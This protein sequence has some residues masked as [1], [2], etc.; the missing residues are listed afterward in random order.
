MLFEPFVGEFFSENG[1]NMNLRFGDIIIHAKI[2][3]AKPILRLSQ[4]TQPLDAG[5][6]FPCAAR[7]E[8][9]S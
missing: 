6:C 3:H 1:E 4:T 8:G 9:E 7:G 2:I 5:P